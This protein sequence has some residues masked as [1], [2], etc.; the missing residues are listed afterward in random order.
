MT[1]QTE[2]ERLEA[3]WKEIE[4]EADERGLRPLSVFR[5]K[6]RFNILLDAGAYE[7]AALMLVP[8]D[9]QWTFDSH[10]NIATIHTYPFID[11]E[12]PAHRAFEAEG[13]TPALALCAAI[14]AAIARAGK[15]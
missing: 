2:R 8:E 14:E 15:P 10:Y 11:G 13:G 3:L 9:A 12:G 4:P 6:V 1:E 5:D 7:S